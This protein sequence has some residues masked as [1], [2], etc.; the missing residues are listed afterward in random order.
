MVS[1]VVGGGEVKRDHNHTQTSVGL[2]PLPPSVVSRTILACIPPVP[3]KPIT[4]IGNG[5]RC[6]QALCVG[7]ACAGELLTAVVFRCVQYGM[8]R[9]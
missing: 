8:Q 4:M 2:R 6:L 7:L 1:A 9:Q 5:L 3:A